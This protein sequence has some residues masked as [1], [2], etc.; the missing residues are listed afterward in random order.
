MLDHAHDDDRIVFS[1]GLIGQEIGIDEFPIEAE[2][3]PP[4]GQVIDGNLGDRYAGA[5]DAAPR[6]VFHPRPPTRPDFENMVARLELAFFIAVV[7]LAQRRD[8]ERLVGAFI[9]ALRVAGCL[10]IEEAQKEFRIDIVMGG[11]RLA[12]GADL[13]EEKRLDEAPG[14]DQQV[15]ILH[16]TAQ[17]EGAQH[18]AFDVDVAGEIG[19]A[20]APFIDT[21]DC[22]HRL[23]ILEGNTEARRAFAK[24]PDSA[25]RKDHLEGHRRLCEL[26]RKTAQAAGTVYLVGDRRR[27][28]L[29]AGL[30]I[31]TH[32]GPSDLDCDAAV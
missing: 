20:D 7:E 23:A 15:E 5:V 16:R 26:S 28:D 25:I 22:P 31:V 19:I 32:G 8:I 11:D 4:A 10:G 9:H 1:V 29:L 13:P 30:A 17:F 24:A 12:I 21:G 14:S 2:F 3:L 18:V 27:G 6:G